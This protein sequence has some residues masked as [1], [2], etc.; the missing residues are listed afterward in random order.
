MSRRVLKDSLS[1]E[2]YFCWNAERDRV[3][4]SM[5]GAEEGKEVDAGPVVEEGVERPDRVVEPV[6]PKG[7]SAD[8][9]GVL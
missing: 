6:Q 9:L 3:E 8:L 5:A 7:V 1:S 2:V 4:V